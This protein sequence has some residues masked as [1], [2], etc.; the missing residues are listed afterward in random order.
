MV[1]SHGIRSC[2]LKWVL[3]WYSKGYLNLLIDRFII[4][5][6]RQ[7][8][9]VCLTPF[10][11]NKLH[12]YILLDYLSHSLKFHCTFLLSLIL[13]FANSKRRDAVKKSIDSF[14]SSSWI[15]HFS[16]KWKS[17]ISEW[18]FTP[19]SRAK[20]WPRHY[21]FLAPC[22]HFFGTVGAIDHSRNTTTYHNALCLSPQ[23]FA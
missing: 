21:I 14:K 2:K 3:T 6:T 11:W 16:I 4:T 15:L 17:L 13:Y 9:L 12:N 22:L 1:V 10:F 5:S 18:S 7:A 23:N 8:N 20:E 19:F